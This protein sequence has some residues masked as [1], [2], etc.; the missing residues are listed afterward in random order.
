MTESS[1]DPYAHFQ[2]RE[3]LVQ[4]LEKQKQRLVFL[5]QNYENALEEVLQQ[6]HHIDFLEAVVNEL[7]NPLYVK[8]GDARF[9]FFNKAY[10]E[11][12]GV[13]RT[14]LL[15]K[16]SMELEFLPQ[17][18]REICQIEDEEAIQFGGESNREMQYMTFNGVFQT[19]CWSKGISVPA[20]GEKGLVGEVVDITIRKQLEFDLDKKINELQAVEE[21][22]RRLSRTDPLTGLPNRRPFEEFLQH[23]MSMSNRHHYPLCLLMFDLDHFKSV[24]DT[25]GH[26]QGDAVL[27]NFA[28]V[29][30]S[31]CRH[32]D[33]AARIGG[34][35]F[36][37]LLPSTTL[38]NACIVAGRINEAL[39]STP[40]LPDDRV[41]TVSIGAAAY[42]E[43]EDQASFFKRADE[44]LYKAKTGG[45]DRYVCA[46]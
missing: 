42:K 12:F 40:V 4:E 43:G 14:E 1:S 45:R 32:E 9:C 22:L 18:E 31:H 8:D 27:V 3:S 6:Q 44:A 10:E 36:V 7:P 23:S 19:L 21:E 2:D 17:E 24:N 38:E 26:D 35:E 30:T 33:L 16:T 20:S 25:Y 29:I 37:L 39:R 28:K 34:E 41:V 13:D 11:F 15:G 5:E 46:D